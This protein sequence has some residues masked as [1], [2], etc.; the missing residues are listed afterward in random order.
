MLHTLFFFFFNS[1]GEKKNKSIEVMYQRTKANFFQFS[2]G[3]SKAIVFIFFLNILNSSSSHLK[4][5]TKGCTGATHTDVWIAM[6]VSSHFPS[7]TKYSSFQMSPR[8]T[9]AKPMA[10]GM[11]NAPSKSMLNKSCNLSPK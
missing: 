8:P 9:I 6:T 3:V 2:V 10:A 4:K 11:I 1:N 7:K 5:Q